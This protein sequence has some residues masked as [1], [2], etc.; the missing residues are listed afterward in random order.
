MRPIL[1]KEHKKFMK[2]KKEVT[3]IDGLWTFSTIDASI[4][5]KF[6]FNDGTY[7]NNEKYQL[8]MSPLITAFDEKYP[9][10]FLPS[11]IAIGVCELL[12]G[13]FTIPFKL[14]ENELH[15]LEL[16][17]ESAIQGLLLVKIKNK[18][19]HV[20]TKEEFPPARDYFITNAVIL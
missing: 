15:S 5:K 3:H 10:F 4:F 12:S 13:S 8:C 7:D 14:N 6:K 9:T 2:N 20:F 11:M 19:I 18:K 17:P 16:P 1:I